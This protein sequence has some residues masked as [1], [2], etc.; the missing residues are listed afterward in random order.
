MYTAYFGFREKP[1]NV[2]PDP[3][4]FYEN[5]VYQEA[6]ATLLYGIVE[7]KGFIVL[8]G[9]VGTGKTT[10]LRRL[11]DNLDAGVRPVFFYN[12]TFT[13]DELIQFLCAELELAGGS[14]VEKIQALNDFLIAEARRGRTLVLLIDEAQHLSAEVLENLRLLSNLET[15][16]EKLLQIV[17]VGQPELKAKLEDPALRQLAQRVA[18]RYRL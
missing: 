16:T 15:S 3:R 18:I 13:F 11:M 8:T 14:R 5:R 12:T 1:F 6:Y 17:L 2:T 4:F 10:L 7:R 9:E